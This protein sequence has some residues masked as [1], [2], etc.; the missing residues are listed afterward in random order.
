VVFDD[1]NDPKIGPVRVYGELIQA[2]WRQGP[3]VGKT[4]TLYPPEPAA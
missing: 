2:G 1:I 3:T 4:G